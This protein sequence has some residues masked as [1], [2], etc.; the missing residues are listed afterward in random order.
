[1]DMKKAVLAFA[2]SMIPVSAVLAESYTLDP[3]HTFPRLAIDHMGFSTVY[4]HFNN[5]SGKLEM[6]RAAQT[7]SVEVTIDASSIDTAY[8]KR[9]EHLRSPD[10][11]NVAEYPEITFKSTGV[12]YNSDVLSSVDGEITILGVTKPITLTV[13]RMKCGANPL[14]KKDTCGFDASATLKRSDFG[15]NY[16]IPGVGDEMKLMIGV[17]AIKDE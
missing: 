3:R 12:T 11:L 16:G 5:T 7:G 9:D 1:M 13:D 15:M 17:E 6:D 8:D 2:M 14:D 10:F 4:G